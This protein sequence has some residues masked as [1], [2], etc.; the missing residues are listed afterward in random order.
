LIKVK[1]PTRHRARKVSI[2]SNV[3][4]TYMFGGDPKATL[5]RILVS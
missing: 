2:N 3:R 4:A 1:S 5:C